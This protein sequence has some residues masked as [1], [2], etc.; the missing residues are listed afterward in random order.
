MRSL[1][2]LSA[3]KCGFARGGAF[4]IVALVLASAANS[5]AQVVARINEFP[6]P[7]ADSGPRWIT[8]GPDGAL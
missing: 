8:P 1:V 3:Q 2:G 7:T 4:W 6:L 5:L